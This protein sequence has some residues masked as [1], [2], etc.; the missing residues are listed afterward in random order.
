M[1]LQK[2]AL[3]RIAE[4]QFNT[5]ELTIQSSSN[6]VATITIKPGIL[7]SDGNFV[8]LTV[9]GGSNLQG[10]VNIGGDLTANGISTFNGEA[11]FNDTLT[12]NGSANFGSLNF[13]GTLEGTGSI[14]IS[15]DKFTV[16]GATGDTAIA[17]A[18]DVAGETTVA[19]LTADSLACDTITEK[20]ADAG[21]TADGVLLK[22]GA[23]VTDQPSP[24]GAGAWKLGT[25]IVGV[26]TPDATQ[27]LEVSVGGVVYKLVIAT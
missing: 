9:T 3:A 24:S 25:L 12:A 1:P 10:L 6:G 21:V 27:Y 18:L 22:D 11:I 17:G 19:G 20:T 4:L 14:A 13:T 5:D 7:P 16:D 23:I 26:S 2:V 8:N 15:T